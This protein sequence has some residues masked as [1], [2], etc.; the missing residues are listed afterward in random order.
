MSP[1]VGYNSNK[2]ADTAKKK[3]LVIGV[4]NCV[5]VKEDDRFS[6]ALCNVFAHQFTS[7]PVGQEEASSP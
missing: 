2:E 3:H 7:V 5:G 6:E 4:K 1:Q